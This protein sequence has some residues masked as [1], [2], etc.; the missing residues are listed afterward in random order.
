MF[1]HIH[2]KLLSLHVCVCVHVYMYTHWSTRV[3]VR[4]C[5]YMHADG[6]VYLFVLGVR[7]YRRMDV[8]IQFSCVC[9]YIHIYVRR[10]HTWVYMV[11]YLHTKFACI[12]RYLRICR[13]KY[14]YTTYMCVGVYLQL[15]VCA[16][17]AYIYTMHT[18]ITGVWIYLRIC[19]LRLRL[20]VYIFTYIHT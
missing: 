2:T 10:A 16:V 19:T 7:V 1:T 12:Y 20:C 8:Y 6:C 9:T 13:P 14:M 17:C 11:T 5:I 4:M 18:D 15:R 3:G